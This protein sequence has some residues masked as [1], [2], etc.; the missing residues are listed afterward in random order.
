MDEYEYASEMAIRFLQRQ[1]RQR[2][3]R[4]V[5]LDKII[6]DP[7]LVAEFDTLAARLASGFNPIEYRWVALGLRKAR[8]L[9][10]STEVVEIPQLEELGITKVIR[11]SRLPAG[12]GLYPFRCGLR[13]RFRW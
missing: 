6:C 3:G 5:S 4:D 8:R 2:E 10:P 12:Q 1:V 11:P 7:D 9:T 13:G